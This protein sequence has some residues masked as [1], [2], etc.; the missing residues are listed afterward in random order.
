MSYTVE[1]KILH[2]HPSIT[3][4]L[5]ECADPEWTELATVPQLKSEQAELQEAREL[6][7]LAL[8]YYTGVRIVKNL[9]GGLREVV[10]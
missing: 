2:V 6:V 7:N 5:P 4:P 3:Y 1:T 9:P 10:R 8:K